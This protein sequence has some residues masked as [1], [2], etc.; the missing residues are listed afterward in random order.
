[1][2]VVSD[3]IDKHG[4]GAASSLDEVLEADEWARR[5]AGELIEWAS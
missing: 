2:E 5:A 4:G 1:M 3:V